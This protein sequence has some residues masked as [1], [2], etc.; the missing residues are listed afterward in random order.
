M[1]IINEGGHEI[2]P[3]KKHVVKYIL[4]V[5]L[6]KIFIILY[7]K[8]SIFIIVWLYLL[9]DKNFKKKAVEIIL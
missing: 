4:Y 1:I 5:S 3:H 8:E 6:L 2:F 7:R 9:Y